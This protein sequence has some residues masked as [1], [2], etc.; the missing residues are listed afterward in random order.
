VTIV[1]AIEEGRGI[2]DNMR[3]FVNF[4]ISCNIAEV[5]VILFGIFFFNNLLLTVAQL[6]FI[7]ILTDGLP[8]V[9]LGSDPARK[10]VLKAKPAQF[11]EAIL[12]KRTWAE[13]FVF[14]ALMTI[15]ML[16]QYSYNLDRVGTTAAVSAAFCGMVVYELVRLIDI[17][18]DY[19]IRWFSNP[20]VTIGIVSSILAQIA[21]L[22][23]APIASYFNVQPLQPHDWVFMAVGSA[24]IIIIMKLSNP[25]LDRFFGAENHP[26]TV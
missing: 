14:G 20:L 24:L 7:N 10:D 16:V 6:L 21:I 12:N 8:A 18:T 5:L 19:K 23:I 17:R 13:I 15:I 3:K 11:Q 25:I 2:Y 22:Y 1:N 9:A 4:L 26:G